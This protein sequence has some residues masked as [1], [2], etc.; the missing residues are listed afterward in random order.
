MTYINPVTALKEGKKIRM[1]GDTY[2]YYL[3]ETIGLVYCTQNGFIDKSSLSAN[4][5]LKSD[6]EIYEEPQ[7]TMNFLEAV[8][9]LDDNGFKKICRIGD[10]NDIYFMN[11]ELVVEVVGG[12]NSYRAS[13]EDINATDW[14]AVK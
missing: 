10:D 13:R 12:Y 11:H 7:K 3:H 4:E 14:V 1:K 8:E 2:Y 6:W 5:L 9:Y